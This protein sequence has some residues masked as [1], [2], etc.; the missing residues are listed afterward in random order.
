VVEAAVTHPPSGRVG[1]RRRRPRAGNARCAGV[2]VVAGAGRVP[3]LH[4]VVSHDLRP[5]LHT[6]HPLPPPLGSSQGSRG[7]WS[8]FSCRA[9]VSIG[10]PST[11]PHSFTRWRGGRRYLP[12]YSCSRCCVRRFATAY[13]C[14]VSLFVDGGMRSW[15]RA[16]GGWLNSFTGLLQRMPFHP[17]SGLSGNRCWGPALSVPSHLAGIWLGCAGASR[18]WSLGHSGDV[19]R[20]FDVGEE[21]RMVTECVREWSSL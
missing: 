9:V 6:Q 15:P 10:L 12:V 20:F 5:I 3:V 2:A 1:P 21:R 18:G 7:S 17:R 13:G 14:Y 4:A 8:I 11:H 19:V 16:R